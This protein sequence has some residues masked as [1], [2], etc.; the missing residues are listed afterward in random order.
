M[1]KKIIKFLLLSIIIISL[2]T[3]LIYSFTFFNGFA[4]Q[5]KPT[6]YPADWYEV[7][8][9]L[10]QDSQ[11]FKILFFPWHGYMDFKWI[12]NTDKRIANP[13]RQF[14]DKE[15]ISG[16]TVELGKIYRQD[17]APDQLYIDSLLENKSNIT[18]F[19]ELVSILNVKYVILAKESDYKKYD[20]LFDQTDLELVKETET[21]YVFKNKNKIAKIYQTDNIENIGD[22]EEVVYKTINPV[23]FEIVETN[24]K[25]LVFTEP[26]SE[27][28]K[29]DGKA[30][31][32]AYGAV[33]AFEN[34]GKE[35]RFER[36][37]RVNLPAY[38]IS[39][40]TFAGLIAVYLGSERK[41]KN[42]NK[43]SEVKDGGRF[44][45]LR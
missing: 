25:Y 42:V 1:N 22:K 37:Y 6:D 41:K 23:R 14:F 29:L 31:V 16:T 21:L 12:N 4:G 24:R 30:P 2:I 40:L 45:S 7:N 43:L 35:I 44:G 28:W 20:F 36:F 5:I 8:D 38:I 27:D 10:K 13:S 33:N 32:R 3:P 34:S 11:D 18:N 39:I 9:I 15:V 26:Y 19:G 17:N